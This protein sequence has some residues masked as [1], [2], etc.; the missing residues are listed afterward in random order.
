MGW[1]V[2]QALEKPE[3]LEGRSPG[4]SVASVQGTQCRAGAGHCARVDNGSEVKTQGGGGPV[5]G[6]E[7]GSQMA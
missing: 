4:L 3:E 2:S 7:E 5:T 1:A 6:E